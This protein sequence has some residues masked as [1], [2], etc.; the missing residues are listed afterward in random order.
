MP[1]CP[2]CA[3]E[4][5]EH[6]AH[7]ADCGARLTDTSPEEENAG[8]SREPEELIRSREPELIEA[9]AKHLAQHGIQPA[10][11]EVPAREGVEVSPRDF[12]RDSESSGRE[13]AR[14]GGFALV[15]PLGVWRA[16]VES[17]TP[18][19]EAWHDPD[20]IEESVE[21]PE[22]L[23][24]PLEEIIENGQD[25]AA[26]L[27]QALVLGDRQMQ[28]RAEYALLRIGEPARA[29]LAG[30]LTDAITTGD[31][32]RVR[33]LAH[34]LARFDNPET[35]RTVLKQT[36]RREHLLA[37]VS[38]LG[39]LDDL[40][41]VPLL[42]RLLADDDEAVRDEAAESLYTLT[43][44]SFGFEADDPPERRQEAV[45]RWANWM[46]RQGIASWP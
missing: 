33:R 8:D 41:A 16:A 36:G 13:A 22:T 34:T 19:L 12:P 43:E 4:Y 20:E 32:R 21:L 27:V 45:V 14:E 30:L 17:L 23:N 29:L 38:A 1:W 44:E 6:V 37:A 11:V 39:G 3:E 5:E 18:F 46:Q 42:V 15:V 35:V 31:I 24:R 25:M 9:A 10:A 26:D 28:T 40:Q 7:C 2:I